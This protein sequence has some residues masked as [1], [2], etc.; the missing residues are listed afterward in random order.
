M[1]DLRFFVFE[2]KVKHLKE[3]TDSNGEISDSAY[4]RKNMPDFGYTTFDVSNLML[5]IV[6][7]T[8][9]D[10]GHQKLVRHAIDAQYRDTRKVTKYMLIGYSFG[11]FIPFFVQMYCFISP[12]VIV[13]N[14]MCMLTSL[15]LIRFE[16]EQLKLQGCEYFKSGM[17]WVDLM[18]FFTYSFYFGLRISEPGLKMPDFKQN[19]KEDTLTILSF[20]LIQYT[21]MKLLFYFKMF[22][23]FGKFQHMVGAALSGIKIFLPF[24]L[25]WIFIFSC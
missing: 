8:D 20:P 1:L 3:H 18:G 13:C 14:S 9:G 21:S 19:W 23:E 6:E 10:I 24:M 12:V 16:I 7:K 25:F 22:E 2:R 11:F 15:I 17:N 4:N 5:D